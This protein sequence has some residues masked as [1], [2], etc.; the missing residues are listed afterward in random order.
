MTKNSETLTCHYSDRC[1][2]RESYEALWSTEMLSIAYYVEITM[3]FKRVLD[4]ENLSYF[5]CLNFSNRGCISSL[6]AISGQS[7]Q[8]LH[9]N[10]PICSG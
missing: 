3:R 9:L 5:R 2:V 10:L 7:L 4:Q 8:F 1:F 6:T